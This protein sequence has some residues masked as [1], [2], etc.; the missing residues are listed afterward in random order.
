LRHRERITT[1]ADYRRVFQDGRRLDGRWFVLVALSN[2][3]SWSR[4]GLAASRRLGGAVVRN[5]AR[6][7]LRELFRR[8]KPAAEALDIVLVPKRELI[9]CGETELER[10]YRERLR[11]LAS[12]ARLAQ[13]RSARRAGAD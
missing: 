3:R 13:R 10:E 5:R 2:G 6:R 9:T 8:W 1:E 11:R 4:L 7:R 12:P